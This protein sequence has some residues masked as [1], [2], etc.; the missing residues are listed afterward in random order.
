[1][2]ILYALI[3]IKYFKIELK[4]DNLSSNPELVEG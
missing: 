1:M 4:Y 3:Y 2:I